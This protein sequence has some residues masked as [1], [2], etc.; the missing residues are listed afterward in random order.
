MKSHVS[1]SESF[2]SETDELQIEEAITA[3]E[4]FTSGEIRVH[5][6]NDCDIAILDRAVEV[7]DLLEMQKTEQRNGVLIYLSKREKQFAIIGD[8]GINKNVPTGFW[9]ETSENMTI[10]FKSG[11]FVKGII[12]GIESAAKKL[13]QYFPLLEN[14]RDELSNKISF[15]KKRK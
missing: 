11:D 2:L 10:Y 9:K 4:K 8:A 15:G 13:Q 3:A 6:D 7:F 14:D 5:I 12:E 1:G